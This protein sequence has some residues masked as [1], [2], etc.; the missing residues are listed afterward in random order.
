MPVPGVVVSCCAGGII[1]IAGAAGAS[2]ERLNLRLVD[3]AGVIADMDNIL[4]PVKVD[5]R[6]MWIRPQRALDCGRA[7]RA[8][9]IVKPDRGDLFGVAC[10]M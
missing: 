9:Q 4:L 3:H 5:A 1:C 7:F 10:C 8:M 2:D 6:N